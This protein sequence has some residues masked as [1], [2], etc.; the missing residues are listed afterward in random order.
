MDEKEPD[1]K[2]GDLIPGI[3]QVYRITLIKDR[4]RK[5]KAIPAVHCFD[6]SSRD[7][8]KLS[9]DWE[10]RTT[11]EESIARV[12]AS[13]RYN[14]E[15]YKSYKNRELY[16]MNVEFL[17]GLQDIDKTIYDPV[18][19]SQPLKGHPNNPA[20]SSIIFHKDFL[21]DKAKKTETIIKMR[22]HAKSQKVPINKE[23][24][25]GLVEAYRNAQN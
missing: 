22:D 1:L 21:K 6:L 16:A 25:T 13:F 11:P 15:E 12:G 5:N 24:L 7:N 18:I 10:E 17:N 9:V 20:H 23:K 3:T 4:D 19:Y 14:K 8:N 2:K